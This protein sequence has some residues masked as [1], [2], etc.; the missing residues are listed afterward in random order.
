MIAEQL[1]FNVEQ[2]LILLRGV[3]KVKTEE[4]NKIN[5]AHQKVTTSLNHLNKRI[6]LLEEVN[7]EYKPKVN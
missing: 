6:E 4:L 3:L 7:K 1:L 2:E 5:D